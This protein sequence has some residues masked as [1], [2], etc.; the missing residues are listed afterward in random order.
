MVLYS[1]SEARR[2]VDK[3]LHRRKFDR[4]IQM[5]ESQ[6]M[7]DFSIGIPTH[8]KVIINGQPQ[9]VVVF[10]EDDIKRLQ[11]LY[12]RVTY[13]EAPLSLTIHELFMME[14]DYDRWL[15]GEYDIKEER[16]KYL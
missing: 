12:D 11:S 3:N 9:K 4:W 16:K 8:P 10:D 13:E 14:Q 7:Y 1:K 6:T 15:K 5:I 2:L